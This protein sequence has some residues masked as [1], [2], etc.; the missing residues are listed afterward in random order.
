MAIDVRRRIAVPWPRKVTAGLAR[1]VR[2]VPRS[3]ALILFLGALLSLG[4]NIAL[5]AFQGPDEDAHFAYVQY[6]AETGSLPAVAGNSPV[7]MQEHDALT[8]LNLFPLRGVLEARPAWSAADLRYWTAIEHTLPSG[9]RSDGYAGNAVA[10]N[11]PLY[12]AVMSVPYLLFGWLPLLKLIFVLRLFNAAFYLATIALVWVIA[13]DLFG[14]ERWKQTLA[15]G[16]VA[17]EPQVGF[18]SAVINADKLLIALITAFLLA[19]LRVVMRGPTTPR[20]LTMTFLAAAAALTQGRGL[21]TLPVLA[22]TLVVAWIRFRP[23]I[24]QALRQLAGAAAALG[25]A[26]L[27]YLKF[28]TPGGAAY[29]GQASALNSGAGFNV[30]QFLSSV[31][32]FY[33]PSLPDMQPRLG[34]AYGYRQVFIE[35]FF[36]AFGWLE[37]RFKPRVYDLLQVAAAIGLVGFYTA[38]VLR[39]RSRLR[40]A[41]PQIVVMLSLLI[42][43]VAF[44]HYVSYRS[45]LNTSGAEPLI[46][47]RY[48]LPIVSLFGLAVTYTIGSLPRKLSAVAGAVVLAAGVLLSLTAIG[49]TAVRFYA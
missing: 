22:S 28:G 14:R 16:V 40:H 5:P 4:W 47:G 31:Y 3:L 48:L 12:Y 10:S 44:L 26:L 29:G 49:I 41:W 25:C 36:G 2:S 21:V 30:R 46:V 37:V 13:G 20:V 11:P 19:S 17:L 7:S 1:R 42:T 33:L 32:Q 8:Y 38:C 23:Q 18:M 43:S 27:F 6:L 35:T 45:L 15:A 39:W 24:V 9:A 34:P